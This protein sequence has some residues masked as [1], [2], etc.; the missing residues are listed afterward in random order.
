MKLQ[1]EGYRFS[2]KT[3]DDVIIASD[4]RKRYNPIHSQELPDNEIISFEDLQE[5]NQNPP[6]NP[7]DDDNILL[8]EQEGT[9]RTRHMSSQ[10]WSNQSAGKTDDIILLNKGKKNVSIVVVLLIIR[11]TPK[12]LPLAQV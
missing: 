1:A 12:T 4:E 7:S 9:E 6:Q 8:V 10:F 11:Y 5:K 2:P 3:L